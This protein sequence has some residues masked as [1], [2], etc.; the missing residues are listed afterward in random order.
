MSIT[1]KEF[2]VI[3]QTVYTDA[4]LTEKI[5]DAYTEKYGGSP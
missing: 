5:N 4:E 2:N 1:G 3:Y